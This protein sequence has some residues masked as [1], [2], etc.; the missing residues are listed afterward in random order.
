MPPPKRKLG[1]LCQACK[2]HSQIAQHLRLPNARTQPKFT[3]RTK[4]ARRQSETT[5]QH[6]SYNTQAHS[7]PSCLPL[8]RIRLVTDSAGFALILTM[9]HAIGDGATLYQIHKQFSDGAVAMDAT[10][11]NKDFY[12]TIDCSNLQLCSFAGISETS[13][14]PWP[15]TWQY[16]RASM[17][18]EANS[19]RAVRPRTYEKKR[20]KPVTKN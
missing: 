2:K 3:T 10:R 16:T 15:S 6:T 11:K 9:S 13:P 14:R 7:Q 8:V 17:T 1:S 18:R 20:E 12:P 4:F 5:I 19:R